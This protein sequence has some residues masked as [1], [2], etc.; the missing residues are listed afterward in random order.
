MWVLPLPCVYMWICVATSCCLSHILILFSTFHFVSFFILFHFTENFSKYLILS[1][2]ERPTDRAKCYARRV[3]E[4]LKWAKV[5]RCG[6]K[7]MCVVLTA[8][9]ISFWAPSVRQKRDKSVFS[10][11]NNLLDPA[12]LLLRLAL[13]QT[14]ADQM[15]LECISL[16]FAFILKKSIQS[17]GVRIALGI[18]I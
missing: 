2:A 13:Q 3:P 1:L 18:N 14:L 5:G 17:C 9:P 4:G 16:W 12:A 15:V 7:L 6:L 11:L 10:Q 8:S